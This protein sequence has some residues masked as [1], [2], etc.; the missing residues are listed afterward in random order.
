[1]E[2]RRENTVVIAFRVLAEQPML[3]VMMFLQ[4]AIWGSWAVPLSG[5]LERKLC[6]TGMGLAW[7]YNALS[8]MSLIVPFTAGQVADRFMP[9]QRALAVFYLLSGLLLIALAFQRELVPMMVLMLAYAFFYAPTL[10]LSNS[11]AMRNLKNPAIE[12]GAVRVWGTIGWIAAN[13]FVSMTRGLFQS[14]EWPIIDI[15]VISGAIALLAGVVA[16][17]LPHTPPAKEAPDPLAFVRAFGLL[18]DPNYLVF[19]ITAL[20]VATELPIYYMLTFPFLQAAGAGI[21]LTPENLPLW[22]N[23]AQIAEIFTIGFMLPAVL[24]VWGIRKTMLL[25]I[26]AWPARYAVF[27]LAWA[28]HDTAPAVV[29]LAVAALTL[30]GFCYVFFFVVAFIYTDMVAPEDVR[31]SAQA[32]INVGVLG[33]G[34][35]V[36]YF[37]AGWLKDLFTTNGVTNYTLVFVVPAVLTVLIGVV[38]AFAFRERSSEAIS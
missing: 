38:F 32:L 6:F 22:M 21:G 37:F 24:P 13:A 17:A 33:V 29:W 18:R 23:L 19:F 14:L 5:Y 12:F 8:I 25:G 31:S 2:E 11:V 15:F 20:I 28:L 16:F 36:G 1:M 34:M 10:A 7:I 26:L 3:A 27:T 9:A 30:H 4:Y 35:L